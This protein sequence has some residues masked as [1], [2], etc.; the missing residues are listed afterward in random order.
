LLHRLAA[1][2]IKGHKTG[3]RQTDRHPV[4]DAAYE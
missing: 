3:Q 2:D 4:A 1:G